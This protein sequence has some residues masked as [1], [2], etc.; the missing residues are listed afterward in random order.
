MRNVI[1]GINFMKKLPKAIKAIL[2]TVAIIVV[3][4]G[5][6]PKA[7]NVIEIQPEQKV[8]VSQE[9]IAIEPNQPVAEPQEEPSE[10]LPSLSYADEF[11][12][13][14]SPIF[15]SYVDENGLVNYTK[16]RRMRLVLNSAIKKFSDLER[17][18][19]DK[20]SRDE[21]IAFW[22]NAYNIFTLKVVIDNYPIKPVP[23]K[24]LFNYPVNSIIHI[25]NFWNKDYFNVMGTQYTLREIER[26][27][28]LKEFGEARICFAIFYATGS[29]AALRNEPYIG[30]NLNE[31]LDDQAER[32]FA[33]TNAFE[34]D[35]SAKTVYI[36]TI[37]SIFDWHKKAFLNQYGTNKNFRE[38]KPIDRAA[39]NCIKNYISREDA[40]YLLGQKYQVKYIK[41]DWTL[42]EQ[43]K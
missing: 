5:C 42:N 26:D 4:S 21:K 36:S 38:Q 9:P 29:S 43:S 28:L 41:Y 15:Q 27:M 2:V 8:P 11:N 20:W 24:L 14:F 13:A 16:L 37:F 33:K 23:Y 10:N 6:E 18:E 35:A 7:E 22:I 39:L 12:S 30:I 3:L 1:Q 34:I 32:F 40:D 17:Q 25:S 31:Q 19:Y